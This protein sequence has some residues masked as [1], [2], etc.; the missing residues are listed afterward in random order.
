MLGSV[1]VTDCMWLGFVVL[2]VMSIS[3]YMLQLF[4][5]RSQAL[6]RR[7]VGSIAH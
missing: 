7:V 2:Q 3:V 6:Q 4:R 5:M 1:R